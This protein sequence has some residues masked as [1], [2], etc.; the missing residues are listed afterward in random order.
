M[1][2][3][4]L[5]GSSA[6]TVTA[7]ISRASRRPIL[8]ITPHIDQADHA[9]DDL[10][11]L[12]GGS[13][14][15]LPAWEALPGE[16]GGDTEIADAR[17]HLCA[18][19][20]NQKRHTHD[21]PWIITAPIQA[22]VQ[23]VPTLNSLTA[24]AIEFRVGADID[25]EAVARWLVA[26]GF[27][28]L[29]QVEQAGDFAIRGGIIDIFHSTDIDPLR[30][31][32]FG[33]EIES[34][35]RFDVATQRSVRTLDSATIT[36]VATDAAIDPN[37]TTNFASYLPDD[38]IVVLHEPVESA[39]VARTILERLDQPVGHF[40]FDAVM[41]NLAPFAQ[42]HLGRFPL[43][44]V[45]DADAY[46]ITTEPPP[47]FDPKPI[48]AVQQLLGLSRD[49]SVIVYCDNAGERE[50]LNELV[51]E[52]STNDA[53][54]SR[55]TEN[56]HVEIGYLTEGFGWRNDDADGSFLAIA[57]HE[58]FHR[59]VQRRRL[60]PIATGRAIDSFLDLKE[61]DYVVHVLH[62]IAK[63]AGL[64]TMKKRG[65]RFGEEFLTLIFA[66]G[67]TMHVPVAQIDL[68]QKYIGAKGTRPPLSKLGGTRW[69][70]TKQK[71]EENVTDLASDLLRVQAERAGSTGIAFPPDTNWQREFEA[72]FAY[73]PTPDQS[74]AAKAIKN[75]Q[76]QQRPMDRLICGDVGF[77]KTELAIRAAFKVVE[78]GRQVAVLV[79]TTVLADQHERTFRER[80]AEYPFRIACLNRF[81]STSEIKD[82]LGETRK[83]RVDILIGTHRILSKD[84]NFADLGLVIVDEEQRFGVEHKERLKRLRST[85][86]VL[87]LTATPIPRTL[88]MSMIGLRDISSLATPPMDRRAITTRV[89]GWDPDMIKEALV[90]ELNRD[91]QVYFV[92][93]RVRTI[94]SIADRIRSLVPDARIV[95]GHGQMGGDELEAVMSQFVA[96]KADILVSTT[97]IEAGLDI[98]NA[99]TIFIDRAD[100]FGLADLHQ[101]RGRVGR[102]KHRAYCYLLLD[103]NRPMTDSAA[104]R[105]KAIEQCSEL[106]AGF[107]IAMRDL[108]IRGAGNILGPEQSGQIAAV[109][110]DMY[111]QILEG[112]VKRMRGDKVD[113]RSSVHLELDVEAY[114]PRGYIES[115]RQRMD[116]YRRVATCRTPEDVEQLE[117]DLRDTFGSPPSTVETLLAL[118]EIRVRAGQYGI[119]T[120]MRKEPDLIF[121]FDGEIKKL[122]AL[123][124][125]A[126]GRAS[127]PDPNTLHWRLPEHYFHGDSMLPVL[128]NLFRREN[129]KL[130][131]P[132]E[133]V[134]AS[135]PKA[136]SRP[137][138]PTKKQT[139][140]RNKPLRATPNARPAD[141]PTKRRRKKTNR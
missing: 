131:S 140:H 124:T 55:S 105:L 113:E 34:I 58:V 69:S 2:A 134:A 61:G 54:P 45:K 103:S 22:L 62:G 141:A 1:A 26:R 112:T 6:P 52:R 74:D 101:L 15:G 91:G 5:W 128:R 18:E 121:Q 130:E 31:E 44:T 17:N 77:G 139:Q 135:S 97:I 50:R 48:D 21:E 39:E 16:S 73:T 114:I 109:G 129:T 125:N 30:I 137:A 96:H 106:G 83:G 70:K 10:E 95:V 87:T 100:R 90:R 88:H 4:G 81:R 111:C 37:L 19:L 123:F 60:R 41:R 76:Q 66:E 115:D 49:Q 27:E 92:H 53:A 63:F 3:I 78:Y 127:L 9:F 93:N 102:Y 12:R 42:L 68:V 65:A 71:V 89:A 98:P 107:R 64:R 120:I 51:A 13:I 57:H 35:R 84:V 47:K 28:R 126:S 32:L 33:D 104:R 136:D 117:T 20:A 132:E 110:Y 59:H 38:C 8:L 67:A 119:K 99:N 133:K 23:P 11:T 36:H 118:A 75:D 86:D 46:R 72:A 43:A 40:P 85:V 94:H 122:E 29:D 14:H 79:P 56:L 108:E 7:A 24:N 82:I 25:L 116:C 138:P 80:M